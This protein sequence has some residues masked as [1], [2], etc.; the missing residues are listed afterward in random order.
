MYEGGISN[1]NPTFAV[2]S[3]GQDMEH[4]PPIAVADQVFGFRNPRVRWTR[5]LHQSFLHAVH[6]LGGLHSNF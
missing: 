5:E 6:E 1:I 4:A 3:H 2:V